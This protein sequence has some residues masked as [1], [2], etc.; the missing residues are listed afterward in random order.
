[1]NTSLP[2]FPAQGGVPPLMA[3]EEAAT[4]PAPIAIAFP[5]LRVQFDRIADEGVPERVDRQYLADMAEGTQFQYRQTFR[6]LGLTTPDDR[7]TPLLHELAATDQDSRPELFGKIMADRYP[8]LVGLPLDASNDDFFAVLRDHYGVT[9]GAQLKKMRTF[10][11]RAMDYAGLSIS[12]RIRPDKPGPGSRNRGEPWRTS[13]SVARS[14][15]P[16]VDTSIAVRP[17]AARADH[18]ELVERGTG[19]ERRDIS[20]GGAGSVSITVNVRWL[21]LS[22]DQF[23]KLR[24]LIKDIEALGDAGS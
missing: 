16:A 2:S 24:K 9:S 20:L 10:F 5:T 14:A 8:D 4:R 11:V 19:A 6:W 22:E 21:D 23:T 13:E 17:P 15:N 3:K 18:G 12:P 7:P 1:M